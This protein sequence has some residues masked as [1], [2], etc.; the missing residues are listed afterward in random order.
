MV[1]S[2]RSGAALSR[3]WLS[4]PTRSSSIPNLPRPTIIEV[5]PT[6]TWASPREP[7]RYQAAIRL[8]PQYAESYNNLGAAYGDLGRQEQAIQNYARAIQLNPGL[9]E[10]FFNL[11][12]DRTLLYQDAKAQQDLDRAVELGS[13]GALLRRTIEEIKEQR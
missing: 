7:F 8:D 10:A 3:P 6:L 9:A 5:T 4:S 2:L 12:I 1:W 13:D 11:A